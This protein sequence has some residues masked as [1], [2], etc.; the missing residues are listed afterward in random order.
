MNCFFSRV[1]GKLSLDIICSAAFGVNVH[2]QVCDMMVW[3]GCVFQRWF[4]ANRCSISSVSCRFKQT[5][6]TF[7][8]QAMQYLFLST[9]PGVTTFDSTNYV[10]GLYLLMLNSSQMPL[11]LT[12]LLHEK[13]MW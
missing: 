5:F 4:L 8:I 13:F 2:T 10:N 12:V 6:V 7:L 3:R 11:S 9:I 1:L